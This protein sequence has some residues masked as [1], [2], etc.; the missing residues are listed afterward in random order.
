MEKLTC[1][2]LTAI[3][4]KQTVSDEQGKSRTDPDTKPPGSPFKAT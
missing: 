1:V 3:N 4:P 2:N